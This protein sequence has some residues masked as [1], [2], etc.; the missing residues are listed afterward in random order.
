MS[1]NFHSINVMHILPTLHRHL[2]DTCFEHNLLI[3]NK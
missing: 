3:V 2:T 1:A